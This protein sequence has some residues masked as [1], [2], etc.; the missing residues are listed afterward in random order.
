MVASRVEGFDERGA[1]A[2]LAAACDED[3]FF[4]HFL[5][6]SGMDRCEVKIVIKFQLYMQD[7]FLFG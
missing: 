3:C 1:D 4:L 5:F 7:D 2:A 6:A